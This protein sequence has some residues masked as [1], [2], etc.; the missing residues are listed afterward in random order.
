M[1]CS[2]CIVAFP[3]RAELDEWL[4]TDPY[5]TGYVWRRINVVPFRVAAGP[6][7]A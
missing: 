5:V 1:I 3:S 7:A 2:A 4:R 6:G